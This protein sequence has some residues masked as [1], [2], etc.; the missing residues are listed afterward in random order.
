MKILE[1]FLKI[2]SKIRI[3]TV[4]NKLFPGVAVSKRIKLLQLRGFYINELNVLAESFYKDKIKPALID[5]VVKEMQ[6]HAEMEYEICLVSAGY[7]IYLKYF[8]EEYHIKNLISTE[9]AFNSQFNRC[10]GTISGTDCIHLEKVN[11]LKSYLRG[12]NVNYQDSISY[13][14]S[15]TDLPLLLMTGN[16]VVISRGTSQTWIHK[17]NFKEII[18]NNERHILS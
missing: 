10:L 9:I 17:Y 8:A 4:L 6:R 1:V 13:S 14:D 16:G 18:W 12:Q 5:I 3:I 11:R 2:L 7:S 15:I